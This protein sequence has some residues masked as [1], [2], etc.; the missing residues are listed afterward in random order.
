MATATTAK[1]TGGL[2]VYGGDFLGTPR[3]EWDPETLEE[4]AYDVERNV[5]Q[6]EASNAR[7]E[8]LRRAQASAAE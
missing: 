7:L 6:F 3:S 4:R 5:G 2:H 1:L 8:E